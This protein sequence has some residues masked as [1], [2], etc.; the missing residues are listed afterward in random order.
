MAEKIPAERF[1]QV[2]R[3]CHGNAYQAAQVLNMKH[4]A[5]CKRRRQMIERGEME[6]LTEVSE[7]AIIA[8]KKERFQ[9]RKRLD[10]A[11]RY[12]KIELPDARPFA[13][14]HQG[15]LH[16]D[17]DGSD[18]EM[19]EKHIDVANKTEGMYL[20]HVGDMLDNWKGRLTELYAE[21]GTTRSEGVVL[22]QWWI[23]ETQPSL[24]YNIGG[25]HDDWRPELMQVLQRD[26][27]M[28]MQ[29]M[30]R[31][32]VRHQK[33]KLAR[34]TARHEFPGSSV[35]H[36]SQGQLRYLTFSHRDHVAVGGHKHQSGHVE[37]IDEDSK[38]VMHAVQVGSYK[39]ID[40]FRDA[41]FP[42]SRHISPACV[43]TFNTHLPETH[44]D[45]VK[46]HWEPEEG[47]EYLAWLRR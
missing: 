17:N 39:V 38:R 15:D 16:L 3:D 23:R 33:R 36:A 43:T 35:Y 2:L 26:M 37:I 19:I 1:R 12:G 24:I 45:Y 27:A 5:V 41:K 29:D 42:I 11:K 13:I 20:S 14:L 10:D 46:I 18:L 22:A 25:N 30:F 9:R 32:E 47:A 40:A 21:S 44:P 28:H 8:N 6:D 34:I 4:A 7:D 31:F